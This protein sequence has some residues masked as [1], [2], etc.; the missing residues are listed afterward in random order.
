M[1]G[2]NMSKNT[3]LNIRLDRELKEQ[4]E[5][6]FSELGLNMTTAINIFLRQSLRLGKIPFEIAIDPFYS[7]SNM[8]A[9][10]HS[11]KEADEGKFITKTLD[12]LRTFE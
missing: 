2:D 8:R 7:Q 3:N 10:R 12:E 11:V 5:A 9:L 1:R 6:F 4:S